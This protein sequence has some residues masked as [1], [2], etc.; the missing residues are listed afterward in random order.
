VT[1][2]GFSRAGIRSV[3]R[4]DRGCGGGGRD[5]GVQQKGSLKVVSM[6]NRYS[7]S[8][9]Y[10]TESSSSSVNVENDDEMLSSNNDDDKNNEMKAT[11]MTRQ[12][13]ILKEALGIEPETEEEKLERCIQCEIEK[14]RLQKERQTNIGVA[15]FSFFAAVFSYFWQFTHPIPAIQLL[16]QMEEQSAPLSV[17]GR[18]GKPTIIDFWAPWC[19]NCKAEAPTM[20]LMESQY[21]NRVNFIMINAD[22]GESWPLIERFGVDAIPH[23]AMIS[24]SGIVETALIG[25]VPGTILQRDIDALLENKDSLPFVMYDAFKAHPE[26]RDVTFSEAPSVDTVSSSVP[27]TQTEPSEKVQ[28]EGLP[29]TIGDR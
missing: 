27:I 10:V 6:N 18:N 17:V 7:Q 22:R 14:E 21:G 20:K 3:I 25:E 26:M 24:S 11:G 28:M 29:Y 13:A 23:M 1:I 19:E 8:R 5:G 12:E 15:V 4:S 2:N 16:A 9:I